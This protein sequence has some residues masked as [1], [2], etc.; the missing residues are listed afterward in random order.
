MDG[1]TDGKT[2]GR[3][4]GQTFIHRSVN[5]SKKNEV[6]HVVYQGMND[7]SYPETSKPKVLEFNT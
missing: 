5:L 3:E 4:D 1:W 2:W 7:K 6:G